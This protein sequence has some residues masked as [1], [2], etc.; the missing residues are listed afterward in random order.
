MDNYSK[1][2]EKY[3][4]YAHTHT[5]AL[6]EHWRLHTNRR[7]IVATIII[8]GAAIALYLA[9][10]RPPSTF[11]VGQLVTIPSGESDAQIAQTLYDDGVIR[12]PVAFRLVAKV[13]GHSRQL[14]AGDYLFKEPK[15][16]FTVAHAVAVGAYGL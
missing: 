14:H 1:L 10:I 2:F 3:Y 5:R 8:G 6:L 12:S 16:I 4:E 15:D 7:T 9:A 11:P 13:L